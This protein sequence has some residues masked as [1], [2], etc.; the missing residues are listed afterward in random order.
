ML[1]SACT[2]DRTATD[3]I[4]KSPYMF[5]CTGTK[6]KKQFRTRDSPAKDAVSDMSLARPICPGAEP[7]TAANVTDVP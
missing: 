5:K 3:V 1:H 7:A 4:C 6:L 2:G